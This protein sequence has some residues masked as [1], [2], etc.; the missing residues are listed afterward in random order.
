MA[1]PPTAARVVAST[2]G[3]TQPAI[4]PFERTWTDWDPNAGLPQLVAERNGSGTLLRRYRQGL[5]TVSMD[6]GGNPSY[7]HYD[8][9]GSVVN[10]TGSTGVTQWTYAYLPYGGVRTETKNQNQ[11]PLNVLRFSGELL[12]PTDLYYLRA[13][14]YDPGSGRFLSTDPAS[15]GPTDP[16]VS[17]YAYANGNPVRFVDPTGRCVQFLAAAGAGAATG[18]GEA[19]IGPA[20]L[21]LFGLCVLFVAVAVETTAQV[22]MQLYDQRPLC[23]D[24]DLRP[25]TPLI[26]P[27]GPSELGYGTPGG[28]RQLPSPCKALHLAWRAC[29]AL[30]VGAT[31]GGGLPFFLHERG[32]GTGAEPR[33]RESGK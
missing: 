15:A 13:R 11:A 23:D 18:P 9:L 2:T 7:Y 22:G 19:V 4:S 30:A 1:G 31:V 10:L 12:D 25:S 8:G 28:G 32:E 3:T 27:L 24:V 21:G 16:Y 5:A 14:S 6:T 20:A 29:A 33:R 26:I 17:A